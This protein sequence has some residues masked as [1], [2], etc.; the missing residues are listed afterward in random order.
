MISNFE[1]FKKQ[2]PG[3]K[4]S[5][6]LKSHCTFRVGGPADL[7]YELTNVEEL[8]KLIVMAE[9]NGIN[10]KIIGRGT[11][12]LFTDKGYRGLI[13]KNVSQG[14]A[15]DGDKI[16]ADSGIILSVLIAFSV[17]NN[18]SGLEP[19]F[20]IP[21]TLGG[22]IYGNAGVPENEIGSLVESVTAFNIVDGIREIKSPDIAFSYR[23][24]SLQDNKEILLRAKLKLKIGA[25]KQSQE[26]IRKIEEIRS[27]KQPK[28]WSAGSFFKNPTPEKSAGFLI[29]QAG[30]KGTR[31]GDAE[32]SPKHG[33]FF[34]NTGNATASQILEL[35]ELAQKAVKEKFGID[36]EMEVKLVGEK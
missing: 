7:F 12:T 36:L 10:F 35:A 31:I 33:N 2:F 20:G 22:A 21:G 8:P 29:D 19:F 9:A 25:Q 16:I 28:G 6:P 1:K 18:L 26:Q 13:I 30:L 34:I 23:H 27:G 24:S 15:I 3:L 5:E 11:N 4:I 14:C 32:I 17:K